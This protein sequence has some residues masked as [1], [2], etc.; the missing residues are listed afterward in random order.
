[1]HDARCGE[2]TPYLI[3]FHHQSSNAAKE[4]MDREPGPSGGPF[5]LLHRQ[6]EERWLS[7][8]PRGALR[9]TIDA[10]GVTWGEFSS[11]IPTFSG[12]AKSLRRTAP[13]KSTST[14]GSFFRAGPGFREP[15]QDVDSR[16]V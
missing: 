4:A 1:M 8:I 9:E 16:A 6:V 2:C 12:A 10:Y 11:A 15:L 14:S 3:A 5:S 7:A 13:P